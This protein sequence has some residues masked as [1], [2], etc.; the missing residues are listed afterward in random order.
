MH[1]CSHS[2]DILKNDDQPHTNEVT[3]SDTHLADTY[4]V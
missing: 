1:N 3:N 4:E 2:L